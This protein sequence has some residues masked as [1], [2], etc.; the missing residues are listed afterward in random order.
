MDLLQALTDAVAP[1]PPLLDPWPHC[2]TPNRLA[3]LARF[4]QSHP[5]QQFADFILGGLTTGFRVGFSADRGRAL[6]TTS[7][8]H[9]STAECPGA[10]SRYIAEESTAGR[11]VGPLPNSIASHIHCS[12]IG[13]LLK[14]SNSGKWRMIVDVSHPLLRSVNDGIGTDQCSLQ[15]TSMDEALRFVQCLGPGTLLLKV[16]LKSAYRMVPVY[17]LDRYLLGMRWEGCLYVDMALPFGL[18]SAPI[19]FTAVANAV[20][21][22]LTKAGAP[23][24]VHYLDDFL[25]FAPPSDSRPLALRHTVLDTLQHFGVPV[26]HEKIESPSTIVTFLVITINTVAGELR[27]PEEKLVHIRQLVQLW[28]GK[29]SGKFR[30]CQSLLGH[31]SH[32]RKSNP[33][34]TDLPLAHVL[35]PI[36][37]PLSSPTRQIRAGRPTMVGVLP[38]ALERS[39]I[40]PTATSTTISCLHQRVRLVWLRGHCT[41]PPLVQSEWPPQYRYICEGTVPYCGGGRHLGEGM[42]S[43]TRLLSYGQHGSSGHAT[44]QICTGPDCAPVVCIF[45]PHCIT[46][47]HV[48]GVLNVAADG[49]SWDNVSL[50]SFLLPQA[51]PTV[52]PA[53]VFDLLLARTSDCGLLQWIERF[54]VTLASL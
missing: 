12:S 51:R 2:P 48:P 25:F 5:D 46:S 26:A 32:A 17:P 27:I 24:L 37:N 10:I 6:G 8:N 9:P 13:L 20:G 19:L 28:L 33:R 16:G 1:R 45:T 7:R 40:L 52:I 18:R 22:A 14:G 35:T 53:A 29:R 3:A 31:L 54:T 15:Y 47:K 4:L 39:R 30:E 44:E 34:W 49:L 11:M 42:A 21:W 38:E 41:S 50:F 23:F 36:D 43:D